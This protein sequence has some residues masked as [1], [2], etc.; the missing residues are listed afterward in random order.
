MGSFHVRPQSS[1]PS[2][3]RKTNLLCPSLRTPGTLPL[4]AS[5]HTVPS[6]QNTLSLSP[7]EGLPTYKA[8]TPTSSKT[9]PDVRG[10]WHALSVMPHLIRALVTVCRSS[11]SWQPGHPPT[12]P[13]QAHFVHLFVPQ[14]FWGLCLAHQRASGKVCLEHPQRFHSS[15]WILPVSGACLPLRSVLSSEQTV[16]Q[17]DYRGILAHSPQRDSSHAQAGTLS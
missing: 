6:A 15:M 7:H 3:S 12:H 8:C 2:T 9:P 5:A 13:P 11:E 17:G 16:F 10:S 1:L 4:W 14:H